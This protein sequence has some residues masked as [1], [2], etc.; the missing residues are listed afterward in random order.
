M[1][2]EIDKRLALSR[3]EAGKS[4]TEVIECGDDTIDFVTITYK[5]GKS[6]KIG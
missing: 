3:A 4:I 2:E 1:S 5:S 6:F